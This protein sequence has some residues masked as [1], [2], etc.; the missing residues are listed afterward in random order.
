MVGADRPEAGVVVKLWREP[1]K[2]NNPPHPS[3]AVN[4]TPADAVEAFGP[5]ALLQALGAGPQ[6]HCEYSGSIDPNCVTD[7][8]PAQAWNPRMHTTC[9]W[10]FVVDVAAVD[11]IESTR[12]G[13]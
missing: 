6:W 1:D 8:K 12:R 13:L 9:G 10:Q 7:H 5:L 11:E 3:V 4:A 2:G